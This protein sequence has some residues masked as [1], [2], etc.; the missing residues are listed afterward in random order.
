M[1]VTIELDKYRS[2]YNVAVFFESMKDRCPQLQLQLRAHQFE[3]IA[4]DGSLGLE[5]ISPGRYGN[6]QHHVI[7]VDDD[8][9]GPYFSALFSCW[10]SIGEEFLLKK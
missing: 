6:M 8:L 1:R 9:G 2:A 7:F 5:Q 10:S 4:G 3:H